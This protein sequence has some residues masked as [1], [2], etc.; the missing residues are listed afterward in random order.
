MT[1][2]EA[3]S[4]AM[5][6][7]KYCDEPI[8]WGRTETGALIPLSPPAPVY[9]ITGHDH[10]G[11]PQIELSRQDENRERKAMLGHHYDCKEFQKQQAEKAERAKR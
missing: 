6:I 2:C 1:A 10:N 3:K 7:C 5:A 8:V 9:L 4:R 11:V